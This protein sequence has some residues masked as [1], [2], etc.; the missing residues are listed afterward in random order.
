MVALF[1]AVALDWA[2]AGITQGSNQP[3]VPV[4]SPRTL[5]FVIVAFEGDPF[6]TTATSTVESVHANMEEA[7]RFF[8]AN[9]QGRFH[10]EVTYVPDILVA[11]AAWRDEEGAKVADVSLFDFRAKVVDL[12]RTYDG[13]RGGGGQFLPERYD[14]FVIFYKSARKASIGGIPTGGVALGL[15]GKTVLVFNDFFSSL[16]P[17]T[18]AHELGHTLGLPHAN[19]WFPQTTDPIGVGVTQQYGNRS[20]V[21]ALGLGST[22]QALHFT[23]WYKAKLGWIPA[24]DIVSVANGSQRI[25]LFRHDHAEAGGTRMVVVP[26]SSTQEYYLEYRPGNVNNPLLRTGL[27]VGW[28]NKT[29][30]GV[31]PVRGAEMLDM[32][33]R[34]AAKFEYIDD[35]LALGRTFT[36]AQL[37]LH[38]TP[39]ATGGVAP[40]EYID[41]QVTLAVA[42]NRSP[43]VGPITASAPSVRPG[44]LTEFRVNSSDP[45]G[46]TLA[47]H[48]EFSDG[49]LATNSPSV[50]KRFPT[51]V[52]TL[53]VRCEV[54]DQRGGRASTV[55]TVPVEASPLRT[56]E[57]VT[58]PVGAV[59]LRGIAH[60]QGRF[61][62]VGDGG[63]IIVSDDH[64]GTWRQ[65]TINRAIN[66]MGVDFVNGR[67]VI[68]GAGTLLWSMDGIAWTEV[69]TPSTLI[70]RTYLRTTFGAGRYVT[71]GSAG[72]VSASETFTNWSEDRSVR[73]ADVIFAEGRFNVVAFAPSAIFSV[74]GIT[75][76]RGYTGTTGTSLYAAARMGDFYVA[77]RN[78]DGLSISTDAQNWQGFTTEPFNFTNAGGIATHDGIGCY[79]GSTSNVAAAQGSIGIFSSDITD[80]KILPPP[81][82]QPL[83]SVAYGGG[84]FVAVGMEGTIVRSGQ[85]PNPS[86]LSNLSVRSIA[87]IEGQ[88]LI[89]GFVVA[90][91]TGAKPMLVR[92]IGPALTDFGV[93]GALSDPQ[94]RLFAGSMQTDEND[95]WGGGA[96]LSATFA[97][98][99]AFGL[100]ANSKDSALLAA[101]PPGGY[102]A[103]VNGA[104]AAAGIAL[105][106]A[107]D[108]ETLGT[109]RLV[110]L[111]ARNQ[112]SGDEGALFAGFAITGPSPQ[113]LLIRGVGPGLA[114]FGVRGTLEA[115][116]LKVFSGQSL[117]A[118]S[119]RWGG[120]L[121]LTNAFAQ[122]GAFGVPPNSTDAA[123]IHSF[124]AGAYTVQLS[125]SEGSSGIGLIEI[126]ELP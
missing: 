20:D 103:Q 100:A 105:V 26:K 45:D 111:S 25:R 71:V 57:Q 53:T 119:E 115:P 44:A 8:R 40:R 19:R 121:V 17:N 90:G 99:G 123:L 27:L 124:P 41:V 106:E 23:N 76:Q 74:D 97:R 126:Y 104:G 95:N 55:L 113:R 31:D 37:G 117:V 35:P 3:I 39:L 125:G 30:T 21:M 51:A 13:N 112:I 52:G 16:G 48:W 54:S 2:R 22:V 47:Y 85:V 98:A 6:V 86:Q 70:T 64:G 96:M 91:S 68:S 62:A 66:L 120:T 102:T 69:S 4:L 65:A 42:G 10:F 109:S 36:D 14:T 5:L 46:D 43:S 9:S 72:I 77:V 34:S 49:S 12:L 108:M 83:R 60:G 94:L 33:P 73:G 59:H 122:V 75:W 11:P 118:E 101:L 87:G 63:A 81:V 61:V 93:A 24:Q 82:N 88:P 79:V 1:L 18:Y 107:Y 58:S 80:L 50:A 89:V 29:P 7:N 114:Q 92:G 110:N 32:T 15:G 38:I 116:R 84:R 67:F 28:G 56:W 78:A